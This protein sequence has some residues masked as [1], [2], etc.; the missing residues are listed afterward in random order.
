MCKLKNSLHQARSKAAMNNKMYE[1]ATQMFKYVKVCGENEHIFLCKLVS[2]MTH[3]SS[4]IIEY[5]FFCF[6]SS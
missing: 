1:E 2:D 5:P 3:I 6:C 4:V